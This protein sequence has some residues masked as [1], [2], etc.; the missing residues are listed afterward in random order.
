MSCLW[1]LLKKDIWLG[2]LQKIIHNTLREYQKSQDGMKSDV[3]EKGKDN[4]LSELNPIISG[5]YWITARLGKG[6]SHLS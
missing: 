2:R 6:L 4:S 5:K 3:R 1:I